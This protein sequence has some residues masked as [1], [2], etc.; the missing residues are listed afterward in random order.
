MTSFA[1]LESASKPNAPVQAN[2]SRQFLLSRSF[3]NQLKRV[4]FVLLSVGLKLL[5]G[6]KVSFV[7]LNLP[8][9]ILVVACLLAI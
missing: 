5:L 9:I 7:P 6:L 3:N 2:M 8:A 4:S 1:P